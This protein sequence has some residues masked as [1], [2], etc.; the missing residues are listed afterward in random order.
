[1]A[2]VVN[3]TYIIEIIF[4]EI[5]TISAFFLKSLCVY[6]KHGHY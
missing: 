3:L 6:L 1:M 4:R 5:V 2:L